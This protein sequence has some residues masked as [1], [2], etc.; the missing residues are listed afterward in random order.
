MA[1]EQNDDLPT[2]KS[3]KSVTLLKA[4]CGEGH[5]GIGRCYQELAQLHPDRED[6]YNEKAHQSYMEAAKRFPSDDEQHAKNLN[7]AL[8]CMMKS[9]RATVGLQL[10]T[11]RALAK[12]VKSMHPVWAVPAYKR[13][14]LRY[15]QTATLA[16]QIFKGKLK[17]EDTYRWPK[18]IWNTDC[19]PPE[20]HDYADGFQFVFGDFYVYPP[21]SDDEVG[22]DSDS[23]AS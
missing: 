22:T 11:T 7:F 23:D 9:G 18:M 20:K 2:P 21:D 15:M 10:S 19:L 12:A 14:I 8:R 6:E 4:L 16:S 17:K 1:D 5:A 13:Q 3:K